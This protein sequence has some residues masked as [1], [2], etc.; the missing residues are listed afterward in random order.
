MELVSLL[1]T[2]FTPASLGLTDTAYTARLISVTEEAEAKS[3]LSDAREAWA[4]Y[5]LYGQ[6]L[7]Y[8]MQQAETVSSEGE[9]SM[10]QGLATR[11]AAVERQRDAAK[12][13]FDAL[14][15]QAGQRPARRRSGS[16]PARYEP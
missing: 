16:V 9:G 3:S 4:L 7:A 15:A 5:R 1:P 13:S 6:Q 12:A 14:T 2:L 10:S 8:L 11:I